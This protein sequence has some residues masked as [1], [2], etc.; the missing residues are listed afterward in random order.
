M[1]GKEP[2][3]EVKRFELAE[4]SSRYFKRALTVS[5]IKVGFR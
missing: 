3:I 5:N 4:L 1:D 2:G